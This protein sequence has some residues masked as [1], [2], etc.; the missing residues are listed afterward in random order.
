VASAEIH[1]GIR[2]DQNNR[3]AP[4]SLTDIQHAYWVGR[5]SALD[6]GDVACH[7]YFE[8]R[9]T[10]I[11]IGR[12]ETAWN[13]VLA[14]HDM[15]RAVI[16]PDGRQRILEE[17]SPY[18]IPV[19]DLS[20]DAAGQQA[21]LA[22]TRERMAGQVMDCTRWPLFDL[23]ASRLSAEVMHIHLDIDLLM[24]DVQSFHIFLAELEQAYVNPGV[25]FAPIEVSFRDYVLEKQ[26]RTASADYRKARDWWLERLDRIAPAPE[27]PM[28]A[29]ASP[30]P[31]PPSFSRHM[32]TLPKAQ[33]EMLSAKAATHG[34]TG[35]S[36]LLAAFAETLA[37]WARQPRFTLNLT[38]FNRERLHPDIGK[39]VGDFTSVLLVT[40]DCAGAVSF[41]ERARAVQKELWTGLARRAFSGID[42]MRAMARKDGAFSGT[43]MPV[44]FTSL[45]GMEIDSLA[46]GS[47][48]G[49]LFG[50]PLHLKTATPQVWL[51][52]Q[53]M[54]RHGSLVYN[55]IVIDGLFPGGLVEDMLEQYGALLARLAAQDLAWERPVGALLPETQIAARGKVNATAVA[56]QLRTL[57]E[58]VLAQCASRGDAPAIIH[59]D[60]GLS[61]A[62]LE[63]AARR[64]TGALGA[65]GVARGDRVAVIQPKSALQIASVVGVMLAGGAYV[66]V[67]VDAPPQRLARICADAGIRH[68]LCAADVALPEGVIRIDPG[69]AASGASRWD[70]DAAAGLDDL[71]YVIYTSGS[72][73]APKGVM[74]AH[75]A[76]DN[77]IQDINERYRVAPGDSILGVSSLAFDL[78]VYDIFGLL[79]A[80][81]A[82]VLPREEDRLDPP[83]WLALLRAH[84]V[85]LWNSVPALMG[86]LAGHAER[87]GETLPDSLRHVLLSGDW[88]P[89]DLAGRLRRLRPGLGVTALGGATEASIWSNFFDVGE[90][91]PA[92]KSIPYGFPLSNQRYHV[93]DARRRER[94][95]WA[96][97]DLYIAGDGL[98]RG[99]WGDPARTAQSFV[100]HPETGEPLY[101]TGD[102]ARYW[103]GGMLEFLG[104]DDDQVKIGGHRIEL[105]EI[106]AALSR[107]PGLRE[108]VASVVE[109]GSGGRQIVGFLVPE[110]ERSS[111]GVFDD[112]AALPPAFWDAAANAGAAGDPG[113]D[114]VTVDGIARFAEAGDAYALA[115]IEATLAE[116][117]WFQRVGVAQDLSAQMAASGIGTRY[118]RLLDQWCALL[119]RHG[120]LSRHGEMRYAASCPLRLDTE[121]QQQ[122][123]AAM[124]ETGAAAGVGVALLDWIADS[125]GH[126]LAMLRGARDPLE[127]LFP[128]GD[129]ARANDLYRNNTVSS[130]FSG[131]IAEML[132]AAA[133]ARPSTETLRIMEVGAGTGGTTAHLLPHL[134]PRTTAYRFTDLSP[135]FLDHARR[136]FAAYPFLEF[137]IYDINASPQAQGEIL[138]TQDIV[139][140]VNVL[141]DARDAVASLRHL[142]GLLRPGGMLILLEA[143]RNTALQLITAGFLEGF[144][145]FQD[146][147]RA[148]GLPLMS[149]QRWCD[150]A[151]AAGFAASIHAPQQGPDL[152]QHVIACRAADGARR[153]NEAALERMLATDLP[154]YMIPHRFVVLEALPLSANGK[155]D[156]KALHPF[157]PSQANGSAVYKAPE[158]AMEKAIAAIWSTVLG[159]GGIGRSDNFFLVG[160]D[161]LM[162]TRVL[163]EMRAL[164][165]G[166]PR[167]QL[168]YEHPVLRDFAAA[169]DGMAGNKGETASA[170]IWPSCLT[171]RRAEASAEHARTLFLLPGSDGSG[172][173][174]RALAG[175]LGVGWTVH[176]LQTP[177]L[178]DGEQPLDQVG[179]LG[180]HFAH[181]IAE[182]TGVGTQFALG[183]WSFGALTANEAA[184]ALLAMGQTPE[185]LVLIDPPPR[186][187]FRDVGTDPLSV[188]GGQLQAVGTEIPDAFGDPASWPDLSPSERLDLW[189]AVL[190]RFALIADASPQEPGRMRLLA[191][192]FEAMLSAHLAALRVYEADARE[193]GT[194][195]AATGKIL[196]IEAGKRPEGWQSLPPRWPRRRPDL[197]LPC[198]HGDLLRAPDIIDRI[199]QAIRE[200]CD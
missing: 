4:F 93:L 133:E 161:S 136:E 109:T 54:V 102:I 50:E 195:L 187:A 39:V 23:R 77:T 9:V 32:R 67:L 92:W 22:A 18:R 71:A 129:Y 95:D 168:L 101:R 27:L 125:A 76:A 8:W 66:P 29:S 166:T 182:R 55:W 127:I 122:A 100:R 38:H 126:Q 155:V 73:G 10:G 86:L 33:W 175:V 14:R 145:D 118:T 124:R 13:M 43:M 70:G 24:F 142:H 37:N 88:V 108:G 97:G 42:V 120:C 58:A 31:K 143:T 163:S 91:D 174:Y 139:L 180:E 74:I 96:A 48:P 19:D 186:H 157:V 52:H 60:G 130:G 110:N 154:A 17:V 200:I 192:R 190:Q 181:I 64:I 151:K 3:Y 114:V 59:P 90:V 199:A 119:V 105:G 159:R 183:G 46:D 35:T 57:P 12:L 193:T 165:S 144:S 141:H 68:A 194:E 26:A 40:A 11:D 44:V 87:G 116:L 25:R 53:V 80:G 6:F 171:L 196:R 81:G 140:A 177:G 98:A 49:A 82:L 189:C 69:A 135:F 176:A 172:Y 72:T 152:G 41:A 167:L 169:L 5:D 179:A 28:A 173:P 111:G 170:A 191:G 20:Q 164:A 113:L 103:P 106:D 148:D 185:A 2:T 83:H 112:I 15:M 188:L 178:E 197:I 45:L 94:P 117:G 61:Y 134:D 78:S 89:L 150:A 16:L 115:V 36:V 198:R 131:I 153:L 84:D 121:L 160:G 123:L 51:D 149:A 184:S 79:S 7:V 128:G 104:R 63:D 99:Y 75:G 138:H 85:T 56:R 107:V 65:H 21:A 1:S 30:K 47:R 34:L 146:D 156:R 158:T 147:R 162:A 62:G 132:R 137:G